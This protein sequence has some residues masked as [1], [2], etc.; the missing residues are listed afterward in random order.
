MMALFEGQ[1][2]GSGDRVRDAAVFKGVAEAVQGLDHLWPRTEQGIR[3][4]PFSDDAVGL[5]VGLDDVGVPEAWPDLV[6]ASTVGATAS[7]IV[8]TAPLRAIYIA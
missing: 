5:V 4:L 1:H 7:L 8:T 3:P 6:I 2:H